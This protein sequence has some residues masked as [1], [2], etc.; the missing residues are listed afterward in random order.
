VAACDWEVPT[1]VRVTSGPAF[2]FSGSGQLASFTV[3][4]PRAGRRIAAGHSDV[5]T[6]VWQIK[7]SKGYFEGTRVG[8]LQL[9]YGKLPDGYNQTV[10]S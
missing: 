4:A 3:Y 5:D 2:E 6:V 10:P 9:V 8:H 1:L 7:A